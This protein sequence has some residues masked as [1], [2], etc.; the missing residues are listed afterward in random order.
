M[1]RA[2][3]ERCPIVTY[4]CDADG[5]ITYISP[6]IEEWTGL[7]APACGRRAG[8][9]GH[10]AA[11]ICS[12]AVTPSSASARA[13]TRCVVTLRASL[14]DSSASGSAPTTRQSR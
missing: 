14:K 9:T 2:L 12:G 11:H 8:R 1:F 7:P 3:I 5:A 10:A 6:Q 4:V 13:I